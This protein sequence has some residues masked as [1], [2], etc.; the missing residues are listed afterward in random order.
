MLLF[1]L[2]EV[3]WSCES[4]QALSLSNLWHFVGLHEH[5]CV[6]ESFFVVLNILCTYS[7][8]WTCKITPSNFKEKGQ[9]LIS[10][11]EGPRDSLSLNSTS[12]NTLHREILSLSFS[13]LCQIKVSGAYNCSHITIL[14]MNDKVNPHFVQN[15]KKAL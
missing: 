9:V 4:K 7:K 5:I 8:D 13:H 11:Y 14:N 6:I 3:Q 10:F 1:E 15:N 12:L 2:T